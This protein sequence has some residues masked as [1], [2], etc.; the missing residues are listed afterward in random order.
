[1][2][3]EVELANLLAEIGLERGIAV[4]QLADDL[5]RLT[6]P[7]FIDAQAF[8]AALFGALEAQLRAQYDQ[9]I[10]DLRLRFSAEPVAASP[11]QPLKPISNTRSPRPKPASTHPPSLETPTL[12][13]IPVAKPDLPDDATIHWDPRQR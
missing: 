3:R 8:N 1:M 2:T 13:E 7:G 10:A 6:L 11:I 4:E 12:P 5:A 9:A